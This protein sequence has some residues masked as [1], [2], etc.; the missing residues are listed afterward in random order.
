MRNTAILVAFFL[1]AYAVLAI[2]FNLR[3]PTIATDHFAELNALAPE[4][5]PGPRPF[6]VYAD[7]KAAWDT[8]VAETD[9]AIQDR[10]GVPQDEDGN[11]LPS[12]FST[13]P[14]FETTHPNYSDAIATLRA[15]RPVLEP[16]YAAARH[17]HPGS[18]VQS[19]AGSGSLL[20]QSLLLAGL[21]DFG[22]ARSLARLMVADHK[23]A[24][25]EGD[26]ERALLALR[27]TY[28][29]A[30]QT[31]RQPFLIS[32]LVEIAM[33]AMADDTLGETLGDH[34]DLFTRAQLER[35]TD[36]IPALGP[37]SVDFAIQSERRITADLAQR[38]FT[39]DGNGGGSVTPQ[40]IAFLLR[41]GLLESRTSG[42][43]LGARL[44]GPLLS[45][46][47]V[48]RGELTSTLDTEF[49]DALAASENTEHL[50]ALYEGIWN[51]SPREQ[52]RLVRFLDVMPV[53]TRS[54]ASSHKARAQR[55]ATR[56]L[57]GAHRFRLDHD[58]FPATADE[59]V[60]AYL[61]AL[62]TDPFSPGQPLRYLRTDDNPVIYSVGTDGE[63]NHATPY[64]GG[65]RDDPVRDFERFATGSPRVDAEGVDWILYPEWTRQDSED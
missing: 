9:Q 17:P 63:D 12:I 10:I 64:N 57:L 3:S 32:G 46:F 62:P 53:L 19:T 31:G 37:E 7:I 34:P 24:A 20:S 55:G 47:V 60:P 26:A 14:S 21:P 13:T 15:F 54:V 38:L 52:L 6:E 16:A 65:R 28:E 49:E 44:L 33:R 42:P 22:G 23:L 59:L 1:L 61:D 58:V 11:I 40:G 30:D 45:P 39:D 18:M 27:G 48:S 4:F 35:L 5:P 25:D 43:G 8:A 36:A 51:A 41:G 2:R 29:L 56:M 50:A